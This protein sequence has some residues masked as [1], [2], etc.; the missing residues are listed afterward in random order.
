MDNNRMHGRVLVTIGL[1][2]V[3]SAEDLLR[4]FTEKASL[5]LI[6]YYLLVTLRSR[7]W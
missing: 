3:A 2:M 1:L 7:S 4:D 6:H 5:I